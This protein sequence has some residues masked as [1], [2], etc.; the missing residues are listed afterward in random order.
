MKRILSVLM[1]LTIIVSMTACAD[2]KINEPDIIEHDA[3]LSSSSENISDT[4]NESNYISISQNENSENASDESS[5]SSESKNDSVKSSSEQK[6]DA[7]SK[8]PESQTQQSESQKSSSSAALQSS[9][10]SSSQSSHVEQKPQNGNAAGTGEI[11]AVWISYL[12]YQ[13][14]LTGKSEKEFKNS[15]KTMFS[16][17]ANDGFNTVYVHARSHSDA[18]YASD[19]YPWSVYCTWTEGKAPGFDPLKIMVKEAHSAGLKIEAWINPYRISGKT[20]V[21]K[22][23]KG[24]PAYNWLDTDKVVIVENTGIF[25]NPADSDVID[26]VVSGVEEIVRNYEVDGIHFDDYFYPT[27]DE[28]FDSS[29][30]RSYKNSGGKLSLSA[31]RRQN[32]NELVSRVYSAIKSINSACAFGISPT[33]NTNSNYSTLYCD[34]YTWVTSAGYVDYICPQ[35]YYGFNH[36]TLPYLT[37][38]DEFDGMITKDGTKL[39]VG[40][41]AYKAGAEDQYAGNTGKL[42]WTQNSDIISREVAAA[43]NAKNYGGFAIYRYD[44]FYNPAK[45]VADIVKKEKQNLVNMM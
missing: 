38:L 22:I 20:D 34:V 23:S 42:E 15:I 14:I 24:N 29:Y 40:L 4:E 33:G 44:S 35:L 6:N 17:L 41:A 2:S 18:Y 32:V 27:T 12:E 30:Y 21:S 45:S 3:P 28:S 1:I 16:N 9:E 10:K 31:W 43:R 37:V 19:I 5:Q 25:Y 8:K 26:L 11:R 7:S 36:K 13:S 39:V